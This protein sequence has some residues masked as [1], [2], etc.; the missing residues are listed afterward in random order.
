MN[1]ITPNQSKQIKTII[2]KL[3][4][5]SDSTSINNLFSLKYMK[6]KI[7]KNFR[8]KQKINFF[9]DIQILPKKE[10][11][12]NLFQEF[13]YSELLSKGFIKEYQIGKSKS[14][15]IRPTLLAFKL[16]MP[17]DFDLFLDFLEDQFEKSIISFTKPTELNSIQLA[18]LF[19]LIMNGNFGEKQL[20][21]LSSKNPEIEKFLTPWLESLSTELENKIFKKKSNIGSRTLKAHFRT[22]ISLIN[23]S[24]GYPIKIL[25]GYKYWLEIPLSD[26][27]NNIMR[28]HIEKYDR[29]TF[30]KIIS[31]YFIRLNHIKGK[32][33][34]SGIKSHY[35]PLQTSDILAKFKF[36][37]SIDY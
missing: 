26:F 12:V 32:M 20:L 17:E 19:F 6:L 4:N 22:H 18:I 3:M 30:Q 7:S 14:I 16:A 37:I 1:K 25:R 29:I 21:N 9:E 11:V 5:L 34:L 8:E 15:Y 36:K 24:I 33:A 31:K 2:K 28:T 10:D 23:N 13:R 27:T 35:V